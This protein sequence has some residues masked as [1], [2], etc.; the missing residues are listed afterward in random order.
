MT[1]RNR[2]VTGLKAT[3]QTAIICT[4]NAAVVGLVSMNEADIVDAK[5]L[6]L[7]KVHRCGQS[8]RASLVSVPIQGHTT[9]GNCV[10]VFRPGLEIDTVLLRSERSSAA[11][12]T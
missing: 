2:A 1:I 8:E 11:R 12:Q 10:A 6:T 5:T 7:F 3:K 9:C 4:T